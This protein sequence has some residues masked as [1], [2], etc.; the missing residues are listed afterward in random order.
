MGFNLATRKPLHDS[1]SLVASF[2]PVPFVLQLDVALT[3]ENVLEPTERSSSANGLRQSRLERTF[4]KGGYEPRE[5]VVVPS[6][7]ESQ[8]YLQQVRVFGEFI[9]LIFGF[10]PHDLAAG[11]I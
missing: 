3:E 8:R 2:E 5:H 11:Q 10:R 4:R 7:V 6:L 9:G 1:L